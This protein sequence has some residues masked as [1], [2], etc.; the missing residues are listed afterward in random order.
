MRMLA[1]LDHELGVKVN[2]DHIQAAYQTH[3][4]GQVFLDRHAVYL[5][6]LLDPDHPPK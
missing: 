4:C 1:S 5:K 2:Q 3:C 6:S